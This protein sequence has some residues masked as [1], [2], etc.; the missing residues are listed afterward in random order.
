MTLKIAVKC[1]KLF[2]AI[3]WYSS[4]YKIQNFSR[5]DSLY[6][7]FKLPSVDIDAS[8]SSSVGV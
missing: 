1:L 7:I 2:L 8:C 6:V 4:L 5:L 3:D